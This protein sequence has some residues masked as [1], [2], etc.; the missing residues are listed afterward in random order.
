MTGSGSRSPAC[1]GSMRPIRSRPGGRGSTSW[2]ANAARLD[3]AKLDSLHFDG[4]G[5]DL[6]RGSDPGGL[7]DRR[8]IRDRLRAAAHPQRAHRGGVH[9]PGPGADRGGGDLDPAAAGLGPV[10]QRAAGSLRGRAR[11]ADRRRRGGR[12]GARAG[13]RATPMPT[14]SARW[15]W[16]MAAAGWGRP[17]PCSTT[18]CSTRTPPATSRSALG[19]RIWPPTRRRPSASTSAGSIPTS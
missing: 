19:S 5:T 11:G 8:R 18:R 6:D 9:H 12:A 14:A 13:R 10:G 4:P 1:A 3:A 7:L 15:R 17:E 2:L 16:S